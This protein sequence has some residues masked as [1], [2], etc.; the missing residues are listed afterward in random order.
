[1]NVEWRLPSPAW[2]QL[3]ASR[4][5]RRPISTVA[6]IASWRWSIGTT[7]SSETFPP[8]CAVTASEAPSRHRHKALISFGSVGAWT[9]S[10]ASLS[11]S[12]SSSWIRA[13]SSRR[14]VGIRDHHEP[15]VLGELNRERAA[16]RLHRSRIEV[17]DR[18]RDDAAG[19]DRL[20]RGAP[21]LGV[22][23]Q[24]GQRQRR[25]GRGDQLD[26]RRGDHSERALGADHQRLEVVAGDVLAQRPADPDELARRQHHF[27]PG[28]PGAGDAV[29]ER[30]RPAGVGGDI[31]AELGLL[32]RAGIGREEQPVLPGAAAEVGGHH[33]GLDCGAPKLG[34]EVP[35]LAQS[36]EA[37]HDPAVERDGSAGEPGAATARDDRDVV[38]V[39]P[40]HGPR[41]RVR[42]GGQRDR[43][44][45][46]AEIAAL[47]GVA[48]VDA[49][50][51]GPDRFGS[52]QRG[53]IALEGRGSDR[54][55]DDPNLSSP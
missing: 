48:Q 20:D 24:R 55:H 11:T 29:L 14:P 5:C 23:V 31:A 44:R 25:L 49:R 46:A 13:A 40:A 21:G 54:A 2:P 32:G 16:R 10:A 26:P 1:M 42:V 18:C 30:M 22:R 7:M 47:G 19:Q 28:D 52:E 4:S 17:L 33:T 50:V 34:V 39:A 12:V 6:S 38:L 3:Q 9:R 27:E 8:R 15:G 51:A 43:V 53:Q 37:E 36:F 41:D 35:G 45:P